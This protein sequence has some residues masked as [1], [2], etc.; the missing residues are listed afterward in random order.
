M[1]WSL[2][3][4]HTL[5]HSMGSGL[6]L[7]LSFCILEHKTTSLSPTKFRFLLHS[8]KQLYILGHASSS[9]CFPRF[10][11]RSF[12]SKKQIAVINHD[13]S[14]MFDCFQSSAVV[15][16]PNALNDTSTST[17]ELFDAPGGCPRVRPS[18]KS[19]E[20]LNLGKAEYPGPR[21]CGLRPQNRKHA[22]QACGF[23]IRFLHPIYMRYHEVWRGWET[24]NWIE[25]ESIQCFKNHTNFVFDS[26][27]MP[28]P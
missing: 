25:L 19:E 26:H 22:K 14:G 1:P 12:W 23:L 9:K 24:K 7:L 16:F 3:F 8:I 28:H 20:A 4:E 5:W 15:S 21:P 13:L 10:L 6:Q 27:S 18:G 2:I 17:Q 11:V